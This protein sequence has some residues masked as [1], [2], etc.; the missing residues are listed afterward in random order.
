MAKSWKNQKTSSN[1]IICM[2]WE[3][4]LEC[5]QCLSMP[6][7]LGKCEAKEIFSHHNILH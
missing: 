7:L 4:V 5:F 6:Q 2:E 1:K 3:C